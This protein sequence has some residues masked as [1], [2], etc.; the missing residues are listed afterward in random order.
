L[1]L[2]TAFVAIVIADPTRA[3]AQNYP[4]CSNFSDGAGTNCGFSTLAQCIATAAGSGGI[5]SPNNLYRPPVAVA[6]A[7]RAGKRHPG[8]NP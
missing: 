6:P 3:A 4:W 2:V 5:C 7:G 8:K 1:P